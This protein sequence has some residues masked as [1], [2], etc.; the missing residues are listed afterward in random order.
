MV[1]AAACPVGRPAAALND[2]AFHQS[3]L[4]SKQSTA[5]RSLPGT[6]C[7]QHMEHSGSKTRATTQVRSPMLLSHYT[8]DLSPAVQ[9]ILADK[10]TGARGTSWALPQYCYASHVTDRKEQ[11]SFSQELILGLICYSGVFSQL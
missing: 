11:F 6:A 2:A 5:T 10:A 9:S 7:I 4:H 1:T 3:H 8:M